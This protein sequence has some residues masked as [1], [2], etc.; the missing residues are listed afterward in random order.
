MMKARWIAP[1]A[2]RCATFGTRCRNSRPIWRIADAW[3]IRKP[4]FTRS[5][6]EKTS[7]QRLETVVKEAAN[8]LPPDLSV[9]LILADGRTGEIV[10]EIGSPDYVSARRSGWVDM[11]RA[12]RSPG[13][14]LKPFIY[15]L[16]FEQGLV[17][18]QTVITDRPVN[19]SGYRPKNFDMD[20]QGDVTIAEAL[21]LSLNVPAVA[22]LD[23]VGPHRLIERIRRGKVIPKLPQDGEAGLAI[24]LG[25]IGISL[26]DLTQ[27]Y[28]SFVNHGRCCQ[29]AGYRCEPGQLGDQ[30]TGA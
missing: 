7:R 11:T 28:T 10:A 2:I 15:G 13:S 9:A 5:R 23:A 19:F 21:L 3:S 24:G 18:A 4:G 14:A 12:S 16:A 6:C 17:R 29:A 20:Y 1:S 30:R 22:L 8:R 26:R 27:L 25:G